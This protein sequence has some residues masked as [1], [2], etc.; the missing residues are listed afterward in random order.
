[1]PTLCLHRKVIA[2]AGQS[3]SNDK[4]MRSLSNHMTHL[5]ATS[6]DNVNTEGFITYQYTEGFITYLQT[7][8]GGKNVTKSIDADITRCFNISPGSSK[9]NG[10]IEHTVHILIVHT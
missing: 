2:T 5:A 8:A 1:M 7:T 3:R 9:Q 4:D 6:C 10:N